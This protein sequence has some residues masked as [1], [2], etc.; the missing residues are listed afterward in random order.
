[1]TA[2]NK[3]MLF[4]VVI[5]FYFNNLEAQ[6]LEKVFLTDS[7]T[8]YT[9]WVVEQVPMKYLKIVRQ[10]ELDTIKV[11]NRLIWKIIRVIQI[12]EDP[13]PSIKFQTKGGYS[14]AV[15]LELFGNGIIYSV[16]YDKRLKKGKRSGWGMKVGYGYATLKALDT[17]L[18]KYTKITYIGIPFGV[19]YLTK[20]KRSFVE[21]G[22]G[23]TLLSIHQNN[24]NA[25]IDSLDVPIVDALDI[26]AKGFIAT[27]NIEYRYQTLKN[28]FIFRIGFMPIIFP[29]VI[30]YYGVSFGYHFQK[31]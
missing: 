2:L 30:P 29:T 17:A 28:G 26:K 24:S 10:K 18:N 8:T 19:N 6:F 15:Y 11:D 27:A 21:L 16:N 5:I 20:G 3:K 7:A 9:G 1:M 31:K 13:K 4:F 12:K 14:H 23:I 22:T 25:S